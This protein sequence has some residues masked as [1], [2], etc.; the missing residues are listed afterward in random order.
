MFDALVAL[1]GFMQDLAGATVDFE[2]LGTP[3]CQYQYRNA[4]AR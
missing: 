2:K 1:S 4:A 3:G